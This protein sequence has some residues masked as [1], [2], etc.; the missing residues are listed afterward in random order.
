MLD[1]LAGGEILEIKPAALVP[2]RC[3]LGHGRLLS[4]GALFVDA[5]S[6][7]LRLP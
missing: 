4:L 2:D 7:R 6:L 3:L 5:R 1:H